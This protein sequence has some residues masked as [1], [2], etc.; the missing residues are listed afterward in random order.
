[1]IVVEE[2]IRDVL[3][4][5]P[6]VVTDYKGTPTEFKH[7]FDWGSKEDLNILLAQEKQVYPLIWLETGFSEDHK[8]NA[9]EVSASVSIKIATYG[10]DTSLLNQQRLNLTFKDIL[11]P[12]LDNIVKAFNRSNIVKLDDFDYKITKFYNYGT[13]SSQETTDIWD[14]IKLDI[15]LTINNDCIKPVNYG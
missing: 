2:R 15:N 8:P 12:V 14:A 1:M 9:D 5:L 13:G 7:R 4:D 11:I 3:V 10:L 6:K